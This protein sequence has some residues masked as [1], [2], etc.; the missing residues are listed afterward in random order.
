MQAH[1]SSVFTDRQNDSRHSYEESW[2]DETRLFCWKVRFGIP[3]KWE[4]LRSEIMIHLSGSVR[5]VLSW[6]LCCCV[7]INPPHDFTCLRHLISFTSE[8]CLISCA[9]TI[10]N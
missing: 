4:S 2:P 1:Q 10:C 8:V 6:I 9:V 3:V 5:F 7:F